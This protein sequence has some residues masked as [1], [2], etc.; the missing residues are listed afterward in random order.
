MH[1]MNTIKKQIHLLTEAPYALVR[2]RQNRKNFSLKDSGTHI[3]SERRRI[4]HTPSLN[5]PVGLD[6]SVDQINHSNSR[7]V[8]NTDASYGAIRP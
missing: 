8:A 2:T 1:G 5:P 7:V 6:P 4:A 3:T